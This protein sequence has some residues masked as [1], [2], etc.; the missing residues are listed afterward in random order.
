MGPRARPARGDRRRGG[1]RPRGRRVLRGGADRGH[2]RGPARRRA[3]GGPAGARGGRALRRRARAASRRT[4]PRFGRGRAGGRRS[5]W[6]S[7]R[8][9]VPRRAA[10]RPAAHTARAPGAAGDPR[11]ARASAPWASSPRSPRGRWPSASGT[12]ASWRSTWPAAATPPLEPRRPPEPVMERLDLPE[13]AS[14]QQLERA[15]ELLV[16]RVLARRERRGRSL[17]ALAMSARFVAGGTWRLAVTLRQASADPARIRLA[18]A[19]RLAELPAP[20]ESLAL[21]VEAFGPPAHDQGTLL[22]EEGAVRRARLGEAVRQARQAAGADAALRVLDVDPGLAHP[23][24]AGGAGA[25]SRLARPV[26]PARSAPPRRARARRPS[27]AD[28][29]GVP[30]RRRRARRRARCARSGWSRT[31]GGQ[32]RPLRRRYFE[33]VLANGRNVGRVP[34][35]RGGRLVLRSGPEASGTAAPERRYYGECRTARLPHAQLRLRLA[36]GSSRAEHGIPARLIARAARRDVRA[37]GIRARRTRTCRTCSGRSR[38]T[39]G[40]LLGYRA[41]VVNIYRPAFDDMLTAAAVGDGRV[42][43]GSCSGR[44]RLRETWTPLFAP[45]FERRGAYFVPHGELRLGPAPGRHLRAGHRAERRPRR[46]A[47]RR[48][49]LRAA[50]RRRRQ[51]PRRRL[52]RRAE[53]RPAPERAELDA[54]VA[55]RAPRRAGASGSPRTPPRPPSTSACSSACSRCPRGWP[56]PSDVDAVLQ[57][58]CD[59]IRDALALRQGRDRAR[60]GDAAPLVPVA[61]SGL[62]GGRPGGEPRASASTPSPRCS[63]TSSRWPAATWCRTRWRGAARRPSASTTARS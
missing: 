25:V 24:A 55:T 38:R 31:A 6:R 30:A 43:P 51:A 56:R 49:P 36:R 32:P 2:P 19:P 9:R 37:H 7:G 58:V 17:R 41:V 20:A 28:G 21:E 12:R 46:L 52:G 15:L 47:A 40:E 48:R 39:I 60:R 42:D 22:D 14:G 59:G 33:L 27:A 57:A 54:L 44:P 4:R 62:D 34:R 50:A 45:R 11:A 29:G 1:V 13:A 16:A 63:P 8:A 10:R 53:T 61:A 35:P 5:S 3:R 26:K 23:R 18:L